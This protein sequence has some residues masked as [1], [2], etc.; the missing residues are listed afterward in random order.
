[1]RCEGTRDT[2]KTLEKNPFRR[3]RNT[4]LQTCNIELEHRHNHPISSLETF[5][6]KMRSDEVK[7]E[8]NS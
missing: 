2:N 4:I 1:M 3:F 5:S 6:F 7:R 8:V